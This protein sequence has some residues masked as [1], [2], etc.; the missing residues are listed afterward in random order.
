MGLEGSRDLTAL[1]IVEHGKSRQMV[2]HS[3][4]N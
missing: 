3:L 4:E 1:A 2:L